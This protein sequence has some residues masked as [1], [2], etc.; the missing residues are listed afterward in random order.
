MEPAGLG[1]AL[2]ESGSERRGNAEAWDSAV[3]C[4]GL[5]KH[6]ALSNTQFTNDRRLNQAQEKMMRS[7]D[8]VDT[9][10]PRLLPVAHR[11]TANLFVNRKR[12]L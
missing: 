8:E 5:Y 9:G 3:Q 10:C 4:C 6:C 1:A 12:T 2:G 11:F 7:I